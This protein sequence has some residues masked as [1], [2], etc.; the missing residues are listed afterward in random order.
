MP[1]EDVTTLL[2][3]WS[4]GD[5]EALDCLVPLVY[6]ELLQIANAYLRRERAGNSLEGTGIV[7]ETFL[8]LI[9]QDRVNWQGRAH[10]YGIAAQMMR[11]ILVDHARA[12]RRAKRGGGLKMLPLDE[13]LHGARSRNVELIALDDA[14][15]GLAKLDSQQCKVV[16]LR[17]FGGLSLE[18]TAVALNLSRATVHRHWITARAWLNRELRRA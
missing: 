5:R 13:A 9:D 1:G 10:F 4:G 14:L 12:G 15:E 3:R 2:I 6:S 7:H 18:E 8:R 16:E 17:F 11:R